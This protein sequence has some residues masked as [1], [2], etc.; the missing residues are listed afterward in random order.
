MS[1]QT[2]DSEPDPS[3]LFT[4]EEASHLVIEAL[5][6]NLYEPE[7]L[8][9]L[10]LILLDN[11]KDLRLQDSIYLLIKA[12]YDESVVYSKDLDEYLEAIRGG[13]DPMAKFRARSS[14]S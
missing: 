9:R 6:T 8:V 3:Y 12:A 14:N 1:Q 11:V 2:I 4:R 7:P 5:E 13:H 10:L